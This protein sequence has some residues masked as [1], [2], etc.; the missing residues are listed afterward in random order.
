MNSILNLFDRVG[1]AFWAV[2]ALAVMPLAA[3]GL[4]VVG[5]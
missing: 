1:T 4:I 5:A 3:A 2:F